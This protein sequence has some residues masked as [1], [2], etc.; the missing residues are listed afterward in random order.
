M[1]IYFLGPPIIYGNY[2]VWADP[3]EKEQINCPG[4]TRYLW[5]LIISADPISMENNYFGQ[6]NIY[7]KLI[8]LGRPVINGN[9]GRN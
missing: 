7:G 6:S 3:I 1:G 4:L 2:F 9:I 8:N 5:I